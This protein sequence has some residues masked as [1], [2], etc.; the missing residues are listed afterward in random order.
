M[1]Q[2]Y[3]YDI[4]TRSLTS[5]V[6]QGMNGTPGLRYDGCSVVK[7]APDNTSYNIYMQGGTNDNETLND[8]WVLSIP[9]FTW[10]DIT[11]GI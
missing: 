4:A 7:M 10:I 1:T 9:S 11:T 5:Q 6:A 2:I 8:I 3:V